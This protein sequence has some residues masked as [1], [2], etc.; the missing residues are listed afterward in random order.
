MRIL[1]AALNAQT[2]DLAGNLARHRAVLE[3]ARV[4]GCRLAVFPEFSLTG[5][6]DPRRNPE[7][8]LPVD[9]APVRAMLEAT[10]RTGV[11]PVFGIAERAGPAF[12]IT[13]LY[14]H[15]GRL[16]VPVAMAAQAGTTEDED[17]P[18]LAALVS[19]DGRV[20]RLPDWHPGSLVVEVPVDVTVH[21]VRE[22]VRCLLVDQAG[23]A[24]L[25]RDDLQVGPWIGRRWWSSEELRA[26]GT[27]VT[28]RPARPAGA[29]RPRGPARPGR[30]P[31]CLAAEGLPLVAGELGHHQLPGVVHQLRELVAGDR[32]VELDRVPVPLVQVVAGGD[33]RVALAQGLGQGGVAFE[34]DAARLAAE[35][36]E[37]EDPA[38]DLEH[39]H[40]VAERVV[41][42][43]A[44][45]VVQVGEQ[46]V[47]VHGR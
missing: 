30:G 28:P 29:D 26:S 22:A 21:P 23:R 31:G 32:A 24:L 46:A 16:G 18:G 47:P 7:R 27:V 19:P 39:G 8:A 33:G 4:Q 36:A 6:V 5:S 40:V 44:R 11:A 17:L 9:A 34:A 25:A 12:H 15:D 42:D 37:G 2:G 43:R 45:P 41:L 14:G 35:G 13:R 10:W 38:A 1:V 3:Q 20:A